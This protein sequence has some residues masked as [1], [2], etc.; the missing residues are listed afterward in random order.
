MA[1]LV[2]FPL[3]FPPAQ[4]SLAHL[5][6]ILLQDEPGIPNDTYQL[7]EFYCPNPDCDCREAF[8]HILAVHQ[9]DTVAKIRV[10]FPS[11]LR[12]AP[13]LDPTF[14]NATFAPALLRL[15]SDTIQNDPFYFQQL[16][17]HYQLVK[18]VAANPLHPAH[19]ALVHWG[20][21]GGQKQP[22]HRHKS[23]KD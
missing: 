3:A 19:S 14:P 18:T 2:P 10:F 4:Q 7:L 9:N 1:Y 6:G 12:I 21:T 17:D 13:A 8:L 11:L 15:V 20:K 22:P 23:K 16:Q 5:R